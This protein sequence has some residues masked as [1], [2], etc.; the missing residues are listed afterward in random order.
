MVDT[1]TLTGSSLCAET[2]NY[3]NYQQDEP[4]FK[5]SLLVEYADGCVPPLARGSL[6]RRRHSL[7][8]LPLQV[9]PFL[10]QGWCFFHFL[11][12]SPRGGSHC[13]RLFQHFHARWGM[14][15]KA[16]RRARGPPVKGK[17]MR[18]TRENRYCR[19]FGVFWTTLVCHR[20]VLV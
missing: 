4:K 10:R 15:P 9:R 20:Q 17:P 16:P 18:R 11:Q 7:C 5:L 19:R 2:K 12:G 13:Y 14:V 6:L 1:R 3:C 8:S